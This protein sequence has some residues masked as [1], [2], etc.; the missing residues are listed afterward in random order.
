MFR[1]QITIN[2]QTF[3][4]RDMTCSVL[5]YGIHIAD[6]CCVEFLTF[7]LINITFY[8]VL[9]HNSGFGGLQVACWPLVLKFAGSN[10]AEAVG[11]LGR[12]N[13]QHAFLRRRSKAVCPMSCFTACKRTQKWRGCRHFRQNS[14]GHFSPIVPPSAVG[15]A[16][17]ASDAG[18]L[19]W[20]KLERSKSLVLPQVGGLTCLCQRHSVKPSCWECSTIVEQ[21]ETQLRIV[22]PIEGEEDYNTTGWLPWKIWIQPNSTSHKSSRPPFIR[23]SIKLTFLYIN[24]GWQSVKWCTERG[25]KTRNLYKYYHTWSPTIFIIILIV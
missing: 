2:R 9:Q 22:V 21:A 15:F 13:P 24:K 11:F 7:N 18:G 19:L 1:L 12:K 25:L 17:F 20:R 16:S 6:T 14:L 8:S 5:Q 10:P 4:Y 3:Q 23:T